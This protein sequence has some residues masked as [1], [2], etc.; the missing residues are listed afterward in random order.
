MK[1]R[2]ATQLDVL[3]ISDIFQEYYDEASK[4]SEFVQLSGF[5][6]KASMIKAMETSMFDAE[7]L[8]IAERGGVIVGF[9]W[10]CVFQEFWSGKYIAQDYMIY[11]S[12]KHRK[13]FIAKRLLSLFEEWALGKGAD[14]TRVGTN[15]GINNNIDA[16][17]LYKGSGYTEMGIYLF[18]K[19]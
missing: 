7:V 19:L 13:G 16:G 17:R 15:S 6:I 18:K 3:R 5:D 12:K 8:I 11:V 10:G 4:E 14:F 1:Y 2:E 9:F